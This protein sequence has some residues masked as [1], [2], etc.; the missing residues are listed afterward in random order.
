ML[1]EANRLMGAR[2]VELELQLQV[3]VGAHILMLAPGGEA[4]PLG[5]HIPGCPLLP[6]LM[7]SE[8]CVA[9]PHVTQGTGQLAQQASLEAALSE[10]RTQLADAR[11]QLATTTSG[12][13]GS[14]LAAPISGTSSAAQDVLSGSPAAAAAAAAAAVPNDSQVV[15]DLRARV[16]ELERGA[17]MADAEAG[18][19]REA[20]GASEH[21]RTELSRQLAT[22]EEGV[23]SRVAMLKAQV[24]VWGWSRT[25]LEKGLLDLTPYLCCCA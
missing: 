4:A 1:A 20:L 9:D 16:A 17:E 25:S 22:V 8:Y 12:V 21:I 13:S 15:A 19:L 6:S 5:V 18:E 23:A 2:I 7:C 14:Q 10:A 24:R 3:G 11:A